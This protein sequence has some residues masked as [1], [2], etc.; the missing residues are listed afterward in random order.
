MHIIN[1]S[2]RPNLESVCGY[3]FSENMP[4]P[5]SSITKGQGSLWSISVSY[6][7]FSLRVSSYGCPAF[8]RNPSSG[9]LSSSGHKPCCIWLIETYVLGYQKSVDP[10]G[11]LF[12]SMFSYLAEFVHFFFLSSFDHEGFP[13]LS[14]QFSC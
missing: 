5:S 3:E 8:I 1:T 11:Q 6:C 13:L 4:F 14:C 7:C 2:P 12:A 9:I 10:W